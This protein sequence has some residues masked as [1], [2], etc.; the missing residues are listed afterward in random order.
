MQ[1]CFNF[2]QSQW[3]AEDFSAQWGGVRSDPQK[4]DNIF[5]L[6][7]SPPKG[8]LCGDSHPTIQHQRILI[9]D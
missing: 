6:G 5:I 1:E 3:Q 9:S 2:G 4:G 7:I 8:W